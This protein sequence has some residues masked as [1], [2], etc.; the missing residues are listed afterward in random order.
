MSNTPSPAGRVRPT[1]TRSFRVGVA[2][3]LVAVT[4]LVL[5]TLRADAA[6]AA[7][8]LGTANSFGVLAGSGITNTNATTITGDIGT[9]PT[10][11][12]TGFGSITQTGTNHAGDAVTQQ[13]KSDLVTAYN[14]AAA[15][16]PTA[17]GLVDLVGTTLTTG[18]YA[19]GALSNSGALTLDAQGDPNAVFIF[20]AAS[21]LITSSASTVLLVNGAQSCNVFWQVGSSA[22]LGT[23]SS[24]VGTVMALTSITA[25]SGAVVQGRL[26]ARN[27]AVTMDNNTITRQG[28]ATSAPTPTT[29]ATPTTASGGSGSSGGAGSGSGSGSSGGSGSGSSG[30]SGSGASTT[31]T[32]GSSTSTSIP[33]RLSFT[34]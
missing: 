22:T 31:T 11:T 2:V 29:G 21:T 30:G 20:Q 4:F 16:T 23:N 8:G 18:V 33:R 19:G 13:A 6:P 17:T 15:A 28:C 10:T 26:L 7:I 32:P 9:F 24:L 3:S 25:N 12:E 27:G 14:S 5:P 1:R 34:G